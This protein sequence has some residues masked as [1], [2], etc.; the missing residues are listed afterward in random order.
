[1]FGI[2][3]II[4]QLWDIDRD[5]SCHPVNVS[6]CLKCRMYNEKETYVGKTIGFNVKGF[7]VRTNQHMSDCETGNCTGK[8]PSYMF[9]LLVLKINVSWNFFKKIEHHVKT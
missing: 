1:M 2:F 8:F 6:Y 4:F 7:N 3:C 9:F 5:I